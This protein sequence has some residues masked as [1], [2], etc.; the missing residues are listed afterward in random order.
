MTMTSGESFR[1]NFNLLSSYGNP[2][3][4]QSNTQRSGVY[5]KTVNDTSLHRIVYT[6]TRSITYIQGFTERGKTTERAKQRD[7]LTVKGV[8]N[9]FKGEPRV[10]PI[11]KFSISLL[12]VQTYYN[13]C[14]KF[15]YNRER[16]FKTIQFLN[17][18]FWLHSR[19]FLEIVQPYTHKHSFKYVF[20]TPAV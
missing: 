13:R 15:S 18:N 5:T 14:V 7:V 1:S 12:F 10:S 6:N 2:S 20:R 4:H 19:T 17:L 8:N 3:I 16:M 11:A 9:S